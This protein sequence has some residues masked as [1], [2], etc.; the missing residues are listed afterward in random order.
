[1]DDYFTRAELKYI[2]SNAFNNKRMSI[3]TVAR[4]ENRREF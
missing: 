1:M 4:I 2:V 3:K